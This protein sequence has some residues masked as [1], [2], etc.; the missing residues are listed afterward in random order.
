[1]HGSLVTRVTTI[2]V[3]ADRGSY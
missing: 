3:G 2:C 1:M